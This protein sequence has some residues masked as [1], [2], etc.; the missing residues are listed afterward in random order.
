VRT[1]FSI[2]GYSS[3]GVAL[4]GL[5]STLFG[6]S[7]FWGFLV[8]LLALIFA[9]FWLLLGFVVRKAGRLREVLLPSTPEAI[10]RRRLML[11]A[12]KASVRT[13]ANDA[14]DKLRRLEHVWAAIQRHLSARLS[15]TELT[16]Q[17]YEE[18][19]RRAWKRAVQELEDAT[20]LVESLAVLDTGTAGPTTGVEPGREDPRRARRQRLHATLDESER[21][22]AALER[23]DLALVSDLRTGSAARAENLEV[24]AQELDRLATRARSYVSGE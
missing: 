12:F 10:L 2:L 19:A 16:F 17:R 15:P 5:G 1:I 13:E 9:G 7:G 21:A 6:D 11:S 4:L 18:T 24:L 3:L 22:I 8:F 20:S 23:L 14:M